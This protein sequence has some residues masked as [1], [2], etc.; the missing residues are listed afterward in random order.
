LLQKQNNYPQLKKI[1]VIGPESTGKSTLCARLAEHYNTIWVP[2]YAREFL[3]ENGPSYTFDD[4]LTIAQRQ[5]ALEDSLAAMAKNDLIFIDT[6]MYVMKI[7]C[8]FVFGKTHQWILDQA[9][10]R[11]YDLFLLCN[12]DLPWTKDEFREYPDIEPRIKLLNIYKDNMINQ[13]RP[14]KVISGKENE[15]F[16]EAVVVIDNILSGAEHI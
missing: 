7:W 8:E 1:A 14:W 16:H 5:L 6:E 13:H 11:H 4:L 3:H 2:E 10:V 12:I 9:A 15:R